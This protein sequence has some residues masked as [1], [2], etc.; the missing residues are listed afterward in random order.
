MSQRAMLLPVP[1]NALWQKQRPQ[2][3]RLTPRSGGSAEYA[4]EKLIQVAEMVV[5]Q[6]SGCVV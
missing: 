5:R 4:R 3:F 2:I 6:F 1:G